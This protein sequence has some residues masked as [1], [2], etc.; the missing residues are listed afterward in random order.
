MAPKGTDLVN[1]LVK[2][3]LLGKIDRPPKKSKVATRS[4]VE[5]TPDVIKLPHPGKGKGLMT[6]QGPVTEKCAPSSS[7]KTHGMH[8]SNSRLLLRTMIMRTWVITQL[9]P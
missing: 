5:E 9:R 7:M 3:K 1:P 8:L 4:T 2:R 6:V